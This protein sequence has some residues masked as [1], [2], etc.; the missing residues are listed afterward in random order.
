MLFIGPINKNSN[1]RVVKT[2]NK[3]MPVNSIDA[4]DNNRSNNN[5]NDFSQVLEEEIKKIKCKKNK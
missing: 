1:Y 3:I 4:M 5:S 2:K